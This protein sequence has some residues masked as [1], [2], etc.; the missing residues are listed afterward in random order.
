MKGFR[1]CSVIC[2]FLNILDVLDVIGGL[3]C[4]KGIHR[5]H[6]LNQLLHVYFRVGIVNNCVHKVGHGNVQTNYNKVYYFEMKKVRKDLPFDEILD[7][8]AIFLR[9]QVV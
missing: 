4:C 6:F 2:L 3:L 7:A 9:D 5:L 1:S 8:D